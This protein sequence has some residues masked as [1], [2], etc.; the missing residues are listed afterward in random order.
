MTTTP[1][2]NFFDP[3]FHIWDLTKTIH[4]ATILFPPSN[5]PN[6]NLVNY[7]NEFQ[8]NTSIKHIGGTYIEAISVCYP[9][10]DNIN[11]RCLQEANWAV[12]SISNANSN[13]DS[14]YVVVA[15]ACLE[16][17][18][19][20]DT[21]TKLQEISTATSN[22][23]PIVGIRQILNKDPSWPR[24]KDRA[25]FLTSPQW[26]Q[27]Y[28]LLANYNFSFDLQLNPSQFSAAVKF[29]AQHPKTT[30]V[31][32]HMGCMLEKDVGNEEVWEGLEQL[33]SLKHVCIKISMLC[34]TYLN[35]D[36]ATQGRKETFGNV[37]RVIEMFGMERCM[38]ASNFPVDVKDGWGGERL[39]KVFVEFVK[40][41]GYGEKEVNMLFSGNAMR[42]YK[43]V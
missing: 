24:N 12:P 30:V 6:Y 25:D 16:A 5:D 27:G 42:V 39:M 32:N 14:K 4:D 20:Q 41:M 13:P 37:K 40:E 1:T 8:N 11:A 10:E 17:D 23:T 33:A 18:D 15:S 21:L 29:L 19:I 7:E 38:F 3:H 9:A 31:I 26:Q 35:F 28:S 22:P 36:D 43:V 2:I 34:Y